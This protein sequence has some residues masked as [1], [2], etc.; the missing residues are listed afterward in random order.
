M[1]NLIS[2]H[3]LRAE[4]DVLKAEHVGQLVKFQSTRSVR[5]ATAG[6]QQRRKRRHPFQSTRSVRSATAHRAAYCKEWRF[7]STRS[8]RSATIRRKRGDGAWKFQSTRSVRSA[9]AERLSRSPEYEISIHALRAERDD[10]TLRRHDG[11]DDF[12]PRAPCG[13]RLFP[14]I[15]LQL[16]VDISIHAL[17]AERD[18]HLI[19]LKTNQLSISIHALRAERDLQQSVLLLTVS[20]FQSTRS[21]RSATAVL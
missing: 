9:T 8:V 20:E 4:R 2:I 1:S 7:Q 12:N 16:V 14:V 6:I 10:K 21:V 15:H 19:M 5:S 18:C 13:A 3:A 11:I 17:R